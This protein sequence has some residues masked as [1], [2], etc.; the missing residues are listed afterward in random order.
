MRAA[1]RVVM[2]ATKRV[3][4]ATKRAVMHATRRAVMRATFCLAPALAL[5]GCT[6]LFGAPRH[7]AVD[8]APD[9]ADDGAVDLAGAADL[10]PGG[11]TPWTPQPSGT[12]AALY[13]V[14]GCGNGASRTVYA[15]GAVPLLR[16]TGNGTWAPD[17]T[18]NG[19]LTLYALTGSTCSD[20][21]AAGQSA[22]LRYWNGTR[23]QQHAVGFNTD[24]YG[25]FEGSTNV[26]AV[27]AGGNIAWAP[28]GTT[29][30]TAVTPVTAD[31]L[32]AV[33]GAAA[34]MVAVGDHGVMLRSTDSGA[35]WTQLTTIASATL[36]AGCFTTA[37]T[38]AFV[39][40]DS[41][42]LLHSTNI[43]MTW[44]VM[45]A[46]TSANLHGVRCASANDLYV[47]GAGA[48]ILHSTDGGGTWSP[49]NAMTGANLNAI[50]GWA[51]TDLYAVGDNGAIVHL[52]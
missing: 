43:G 22:D 7:D 25:V 18:F 41:G 44:I 49:E 4:R 39:V 21:Y 10:T 31:T 19:N 1:K 11:G 45:A 46:P 48:T 36:R 34:T 35:S 23:W 27:G 32:R 15:A 3:M 6:L 2:R 16:S 17:P 26:V 12:T 5:A 14:W 37:G 50:W 40:G 9:A 13:A 51:P 24:L 20:V 38:E 42:A 47:V 52:P 33:F 29:S 8:A 28:N 30:F